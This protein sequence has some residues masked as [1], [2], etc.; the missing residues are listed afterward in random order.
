MDSIIKKLQE[1]QSVII[2]AHDSEDPDAI[3]SSCAMKEILKNMGKSARVVLSAPM[4][5]KFSQLFDG[6]EVYNEG[7]AYDAQLCVCLDCGDRQ[8]LGARVA[9]FR[10]I[11]NSVNIDHHY[12]NDNFA[13][14]NYVDGSASATAEILFELFEKMGAPLTQKAA[15]YLYTAISADTGGFK[16]SNVSPKTMRI[17]AELISFDIGHADIARIL[18][19]TESMNIIKLKGTIM[20]NIISYAGGTVNMVTVEDKMFAKYGIDEKDIPDLVDIPRSVEGT[21]IAVSIKR[22][23][24]KIKLSF[25]SNGIVNVAEIAERFGGGGHAMAAGGTIT[26]GSLK[27]AE[28]RVAEECTKAVIKAGLYRQ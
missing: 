5:A 18:F 2:L 9:V 12:T 23:D 27:D 6:C 3:G 11:E 15:K 8:R 26:E 24:T 14:E 4:S 13:D 21:Q 19:D 20:R 17:G 22:L 10:N 16:Y 7:N 28:R 1:A 25:R